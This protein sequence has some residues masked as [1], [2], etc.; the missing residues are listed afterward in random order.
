MHLGHIHGL[1]L[2]T[3]GS[4]VLNQTFSSTKKLLMHSCSNWIS[5]LKNVKR[6]ATTA[7]TANGTVQWHSL[8]HTNLLW[9]EILPKVL[10]G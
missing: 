9:E 2:E 8:T 6:E 1:Q 10:L 5:E 3:S 7:S 4:K